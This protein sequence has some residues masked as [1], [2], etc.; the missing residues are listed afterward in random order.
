MNLLHRIR[1]MF[2]SEAEIPAEARLD[3]PIEQRDYLLDGQLRTWD[4]A[5]ED[6]LSPVCLRTASGIERA[7][8]GSFPL[9]GE[10][11][12]LAA[13]DA[14]VA[15]YANGC[16]R[17]P[18]LSVAAR[19]EH[20]QEFARRM[21]NRREEVVRLLM[22]E[23]G[24]SLADS[25]KEFDRTLDY[26][27]DTI[28]A[29]KDLDR[30][31]SRFVIHQG[32]IGQVRRAPL[33]VVLCMGPSNYPLNETFTTLIPALIMGTTVVMKC[34]RPGTLLHRPLLEALRDSFPPGVVNTIYGQGRAV[35]P[36]LMAS[37]KVDVLAFIGSPGAADSLKKQHPRPHRLRCVLGLAAKNAGIILPDADLDLTVRECILGTL[38]YNGQRCTALKILFVHSSI[39]KPF[40]ERFADAVNRVPFGMPWDKDVLVTPLP[41]PE[42]VHRHQELI[43][44]AKTHGA[45]IIN[46]AGGTAE[47]TYLHPAIL[48]PANEKMRL[49]REEQWGPVIP[50]LP[51][52][53][54]ETPI[55]Y[56]I[57]SPY[58][59]QV[60]LFGRDPDTLAKLIDPLVNQVCRVNLNS[61]CQ[62]GPDIFP[63][64]GRKDSAEGTLSVSDALRVFSIRTLVAAK[65]SD[66]NKG[67]INRIVR[68]R[69]SNFLSTDF[70]L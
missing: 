63:F 65:A 67:I 60:S 27:A 43:E 64:T 14:A 48:Y 15:A 51:F 57:Q 29:L 31:S 9:F 19:I 1:S 21:K 54:V 47:H 18:T 56:V 49:Y 7:R 26:I 59:Q 35:A 22:W 69:K 61:Q 34:P 32:V 62:R 44:D 28:D 39:L 2:P 17:W 46:E 13:L 42:S 38:S 11:E 23:I 58:G 20:M 30:V 68:E 16:G 5:V 3:H 53:S 70:I 6:A 41:D 36:P 10:R 24:K 52:D 4:G 33:G 12:A 50:V 40:L 55:Q 25:Q 8:I 45:E 37:G 66:L